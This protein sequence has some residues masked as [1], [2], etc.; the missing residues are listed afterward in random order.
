MNAP[1]ARTKHCFPIAACMLGPLLLLFAAGCGQRHAEAPTGQSAD[2]GAKPLPRDDKPP[3]VGGVLQSNDPDALQNYLATVKEITPTTFKV[4]WSPATVAFDKAATMRALRG[5]SLDGRRFKLDPAEPAVAKL[6]PG[7]ILWL[8]DV[9]VSKVEHVEH[10]HG[11]AVVYT[12]PVPLNEAIPN[13][14]IAFDAK[15]PVSNFMLGRQPPQPQPTAHASTCSWWALGSPTR[16]SR[17]AMRSSR[18]LMNPTP[19]S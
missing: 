13:A 8:Y 5:V 19:R 15:A 11:S 16:A 7:S 1:L 3:W 18:V 10:S 17:A 4:E 12:V 6:A 2:S 9:T 14:E